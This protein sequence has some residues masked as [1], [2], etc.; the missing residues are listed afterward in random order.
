MRSSLR[1]NIARKNRNLKL[2]RDAC[3]IS[4]S[5][6]NYWVS[7]FV[8]CPGTDL[9]TA[10]LMAVEHQLLLFK[11][12]FAAFKSPEVILPPALDTRFS[13]SHNTKCHPPI[14][15]LSSGHPLPT[16]P[17]YK[18]EL[19]FPNAS[20]FLL[21]GKLQMTSFLPQCLPQNTMS[22]SPAQVVPLLQSIFT[23]GCFPNI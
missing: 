3:L 4:I 22:T 14:S 6:H 15:P 11:D 20:I 19:S 12:N 2:R 23:F 10:L 1:G 9:L 18:H 5:K 8:R 13:V 17:S 7:Q 16:L 21:E